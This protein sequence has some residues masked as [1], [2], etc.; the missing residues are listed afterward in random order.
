MARLPTIGGD[1]SSWGVVLNTYL[2]VAHNADGSLKNHFAN[3]KD[4]AFGA[5]GDNVTNDTAAIQAA[6]DSLAVTGG[7]VFFPPGTYDVSSPLTIASQNVRLVGTGAG[8][9]IQPKNTFS[10]SQII[11]L[12]DNFTGVSNMQIAFFSGPYSGNP[13]ADAIKVSGAVGVVCRDLFIQ[14]INGWGINSIATS[15]NA[16]TNLVVDNVHVYQ[17]A[18]G[19]HSQGV[20]G[21][22]WF[23]VQHF[24]N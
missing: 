5:V 9:I 23:G 8:S 21:S 10:G 12:S 20:S 24:L 15:S 1:N 7:I 2:G 6:I 18:Q 22:N 17:S 13:A 3:V 11:L 14:T 19:I 4:P 16:C